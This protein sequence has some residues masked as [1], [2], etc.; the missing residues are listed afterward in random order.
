MKKLV[1]LI[2]ILLLSLSLTGC[3]KIDL[4]NKSLAIREE[5]EITNNLVIWEKEP[6]IIFDSINAIVPYYKFLTNIETNLRGYPVN[7]DGN[8][9][10]PNAIEVKQ[11]NMYGIYDYSGNVLQEPIA[12]LPLDYAY[13]SKFFVFNI[14][15]TAMNYY[16]KLSTDFKELIRSNEG[17]GIGGV[18]DIYVYKDGDIYYFDIITNDIKNCTN[19]FINNNYV[20]M[21]QVD[22]NFNR[23]GNVILLGNEL[24]YVS[25]DNICSST[26]I[27]DKYLIS[28]KSQ[29]TKDVFDSTY[30]A[31]GSKESHLAFVDVKTGNRITDF[32]YD[33]ALF[34]EDGYAPVKKGDYWGFIDEEG[35][36]VTDFVFTD[37]S[38]LYDGKS[39]VAVDGIYGVIN[40]V[41]TL[42]QNIRITKETI[43]TDIPE[44]LIEELEKPIFNVTVLVKKLNIRANPTTA[45][46][47][48]GAA[49]YDD[50]FSVYETKQD[51]NYTWY[52]INK[53]HWSADDDTWLQIN[54]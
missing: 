43:I 30:F 4:E 13:V 39:W 41:E 31:T 17:Y 26:F 54:N 15:D 1:L 19:D 29:L 53:E 9:Y 50:F 45:A 6:F 48:V 10:T 37:A 24:Q 47:I 49:T 52:R 25:D 44:N 12:E 18:P 7:F 27:N 8:D 23:I 11:Y 34:F 36:E 2:Y 38:S 40:L 42:K 35:N 28:E 5:T 33:D 16:S 21:P 20:I 14:K 46:E 51:S 32:L 22:N 3:Q